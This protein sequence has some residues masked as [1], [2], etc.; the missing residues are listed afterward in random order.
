MGSIKK[1]LLY[2]QEYKNKLILAVFLI[3]LSVVASIIPYI[4]TYDMILSFVE[5]Q[6][7][8]VGYIVMMAGAVLISL[9]LQSYLYI[10][11]LTVSHEVAFDT[12]MGIRKSMAK[13]MTKLP[14][15]VINDKG[16]G[17][18]K[19]YLVDDIESVETLIAHMIPEGIPYMVAPII[20][21][22][23]LFF[24]DWRLALLAMGSI[25][26]GVG[27]FLLM[28]VAGLK[29]MKVYYSAA[30]DMNATI[31]EYIS[32]MEVIKIFNRT[33][34]SYENYRDSVNKYR[35][36]TLDWFKSSW[37]YMAIYKSVLPC[38]VILL[39]PVGTLFYINGTLEF[40]TF[41]YA[42]LLSISIGIPLIKLMNFAMSFPNLKYKIEQIEKEFAGEE[43][44][45][46][47]TG[48]IPNNHN[49]EFR[50]VTFAYDKKEVVKDVTF[51]AKENTVTAIVGE[52]GSGKSTL[53][54]LLVHFWD[55]SEGEILVGGVNIK[56]IEFNALMRIIS[57]VSQDTFLFNM[58]IMDNIRVGK[59]EATDEEVI[60]AAKL[61]MCH[62]FIINMKNG[63][64]SMAGDAGDKLSGGEKQRITIARAILKNAPVIIL[65]EATA[66]TDSENE[67]KIQEALNKLIVGKT[68]IVIAHRLSTIVK[69]NNIILMHQGTLMQQ[70]THEELLEHSK[71]Y[72]ILW[73]AHIQSI[74]WDI[75][76][77][78]AKECLV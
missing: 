54:K 78:E 57:Y 48:V 77:K 16:T 13:K 31:V 68:L 15:G 73:E 36:Y 3:F 50:N 10:K 22:I 52:S 40:S 26:I 27:A 30:Q 47:E 67:D 56:N 12:L 62:E 55:V 51:S 4:I 69:A 39:L 19:K 17:R 71:E 32:G 53:A 1:I 24:L 43:L 63:Y 35:D 76:T 8:T 11:G 42:L 59:E 72:Q 6:S 5:R 41:V 58:S 14:L 9:L 33:T 65:D 23:I 2:A 60:E 28:M 7:I 74:N 18:Y 45:I 70:G 61:A 34:H 38:T 37:T 46:N 44:E 75:Q 25:P 64:D 49:I 20:V 66:Y 21:Y 29:K